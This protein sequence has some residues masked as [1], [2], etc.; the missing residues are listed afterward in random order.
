MTPLA[1]V[2]ERFST[3]IIETHSFR[4]DETAVIRPEAL[5]PVAQFLKEAP[6]LDFNFLMDLSAVDYLFFAGGRIQKPARFEVVYHF[7]SLKF[8]HRLRLKVPVDEKAPEVDSLCALWASANWYE[9]EVWDMFGI[10]FKGHPNLKRILMYEE[11]Q[12]HALRKDYPFNK[13]QPLIGPQY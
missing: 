5:R 4:G 12:G 6:E 9:R 10:K 7:F 2:Q 11:F 1:R 13:R 8:N 3:Q